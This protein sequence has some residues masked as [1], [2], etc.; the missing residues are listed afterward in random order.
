MY[1]SRSSTEFGSLQNPK[2]NVL[3]QNLHEKDKKKTEK[4]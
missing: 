3:L 4:Q 2:E 1:N